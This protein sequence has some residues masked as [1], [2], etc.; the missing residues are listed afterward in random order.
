MD[1]TLFIVCNCGLPEHQFA[2]TEDK[3]E[4]WY[5]MNVHLSTGNFWN[6]L[7]VAVKYLFGYRCKYGEFEE[8]I[9]DRDQAN[10]ITR[11]LTKDCADVP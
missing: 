4:D 3:E 11:F 1:D 8:I 7:I 5:Y 2:I 6:R 10:R 9:I